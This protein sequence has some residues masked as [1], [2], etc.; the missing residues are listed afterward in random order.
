MYPNGRDR[1]VPVVSI[2]HTREGS[3]TLTNSDG[4]RTDIQLQGSNTITQFS[5]P[6]IAEISLGIN[7]DKRAMELECTT[8]VSFYIFLRRQVKVG[9]FAYP[10]LPLES[11]SNRYIIPS[12]PNNPMLGIAAIS[13]NTTV[14]VEF[15]TKCTYYFGWTRLKGGSRFTKVL[16]KRD[17]LQIAGRIL[18]QLEYCDLGGSIVQSSEPV[19]VFS[20]SPGIYYQGYISKTVM[21]QVPPVT[22]WG[23]KFIVPPPL[24]SDM[25]R[26]SIVAAY[27]DT[28]V[29][30]ELPTGVKTVHLNESEFYVENTKTGLAAAYIHST[31]PILIQQIFEKAAGIVPALDDYGTEYLIPDLQTDNRKYQRHV[32]LVTS[33]DCTSHINVN[34]TWTSQLNTSHQVSFT[35]FTDS[36]NL[37]AIRSNSS[38][39]PFAVRVSVDSSWESLGFFVSRHKFQEEGLFSLNDTQITKESNIILLISY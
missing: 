39:C 7:V 36:Y 37:T 5:L 8:D 26:I 16:N 22:A 12:V 31:K 35:G 9:A 34:S 25:F 15:K 20:G 4:N 23:T 33:A 21:S 28:T 38:S 13:D 2:G 3:C 6:Y 18:T 29:I 14:T 30:R 27:N 11:L 32:V 19:A 10:V 24:V 1:D 17:V